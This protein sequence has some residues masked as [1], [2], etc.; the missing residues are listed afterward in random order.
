MISIEFSSWQ[1]DYNA[2]IKRWVPHYDQLIS[3]TS[4]LPPDF[5]PMDILDLGCGN[6][7][8]VAPLVEHFPEAQFYLVDSSED[9]MVAVQK[10]FVGKGD[11]IFIEKKFQNLSILANSLDLI[12]ACL[13]IHHLESEEKQQLFRDIFHWLRPGGI[14]ICT[15]LFGNK[16]DPD[17]Q[18]KVMQP[19]EGYA[20]SRGT[21]DEE[22]EMMIEHH[23]QYDRPD[24]VED[25]VRWM[26]Q[27]GFSQVDECMIDRNF[28]TILAYKD[29]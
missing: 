22:W 29:R 3:Q 13:S 20:R 12:I 5:K 15:D 6:G 10:R 25:H 2:K 17:Y 24:R 23:A 11:F 28:G 27:A 7:N 18:E 1:Q 21:T 9:M 8:A 16:A 19:W 14:F 26:H 4:D